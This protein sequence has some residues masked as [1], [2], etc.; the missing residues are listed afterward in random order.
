MTGRIT[1][2]RAGQY[3]RAPLA[4]VALPLLV[5]LAAVASPLR[6]DAAYLN[7]GLAYDANSQWL[8]GSATIDGNYGITSQALGTRAA[9]DVLAGRLPLWNHDEGLGTPLLG[10]MQSAA[11]FPPTWLMAIPHGQV[12]EQALLQFVAGIGTL[13]FLRRLGLGQLPA[14]AGGIAFEVNGVFSW[15]RNAVFN[16]VAFLPWLFLAVELMWACAREERD[17]TARSSAIGLAAG[18]AALALYAGFPEQV[19]LYAW[20]L[21][22]WTVYR[23]AT[24][25]PSRIVGFAVDLILAGLLALA[26]SAPLLTAFADYLPQAELGGHGEGF[27]SEGVNPGG[28]IQHLVPYIYGTISGALNEDLRDVWD[29][30]GGYIGFVP[31]VLAVAA[32][33]VPRRRPVKAL[34]VGWVVLAVGATYGVP[35]LLQGFAALP[36]M[37][38]VAFGRYL[39]ASW[40]FSI[41][42]LAALFLDDVP[43]LSWRGLRLTLAIALVLVLVLCAGAVAA[44]WSAITALAASSKYIRAAF[45]LAAWSTGGLALLLLAVAWFAKPRRAAFPLAVALVLEGA[46]WFTVPFLSYPRHGH[47]DLD[48]VRYLRTEAGFDRVFGFEQGGLWPNYGSAYGIAEI[49]YDDLPTPKLTSAYA[50]DALDSY[51]GRLSLLPVSWGLPSEQEAERRL[52]FHSR[53]PAYARSGVALLL[54]GAGFDLVSPYGTSDGVDAGTVRLGPNNLIEVKG[55]AGPRLKLPISAL[56]VQLRAS[57]PRVSGRLTGRLCVDADC[58]EGHT[59]LATRGDDPLSIVLDRQLT[60]TPGAPYS[61]TLARLDGQGQAEIALRGLD[62]AGDDV[63]VKPM[64]AARTVPDIHFR[65]ANLTLV[66][67]ARTTE[68]YRIAGTRAYFSAPGCRLTT[69]SRDAVDV[70]CTASSRLIRLELAMPGWTAKI[71]G[72]AAPVG[73]EETVFQGVD[74][75][76]GDN[77]V[78]FAFAPRGFNAA[79]VAAATAISVLSIIAFAACRRVLLRG[80]QPSPM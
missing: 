10:E 55:R 49:G 36:L 50:R 17:W 21:A 57:A 27:K 5:V 67:V 70:S 73:T 12:L 13:L 54:A 74:V 48:L 75:L 61:L 64:I 20:L 62:E 35:G 80:R 41:L 4:L 26:A 30:T 63:A 46:A 24:L 40:V 23:M 15:L 69:R 32:L 1:I 9:N 68:V 60:I 47:L 38:V 16:P 43:T 79:L 34:L 45:R 22:A 7:S 51:A 78:T 14:A 56:T 66:H 19:Y 44:D 2:K 37:N 11:L 71:N 58:A 18:M 77:E 42:V 31:V 76:A 59:D 33:L 8:A 6:I 3:G 39:V 28:L 65:D 29:G 52:E 25:P 53:L 72:I